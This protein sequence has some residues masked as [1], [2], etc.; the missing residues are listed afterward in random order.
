MQRFSII[1]PTLNEAENIHPLL[2][3]IEQV[4]LGQDLLPEVIFVDDG[5]YDGTC[6]NIESYRGAFPVRLI[7]RENERGL[8]GAVVAGS[9]SA[10]NDLIVVMDADLSHPPEIIPE[11][12]APL[13]ESKCD[14][15]IG[16]RY[17]KGGDTPGW[18]YYRK[19]SSQTASFPARLLSGVRDPLAGFFA[20]R[21][22]RILAV[23]NGHTGFKILLDILAD[24]ITPLV[25]RE[26]PITFHER[27]AG[28]S[29]MNVQVLCSYFSQV[30]QLSANKLPYGESS[31]FLP[32]IVL[33]GIM[34]ISLSGTLANLG[35]MH[36]NFS[37]FAGL[38]ITAHLGYFILPFLNK[39]DSYRFNWHSYL[40][41]LA[42]TLLLLFLRDGI[43]T[44]PVFQN[45]TPSVTAHFLST[46]VGLT[47]VMALSEQNIHSP[48]KNGLNWKWFGG[49]LIFYAVLIRIVFLGNIELLREEA[50]YWNYAQ[51]MAPGYLDH[52]PMV[53]LLIRWGTLMFGDNE[54]GVRFFTFLCWFITAFFTYRLTA[55]IFEKETAFRAVVLIA[56]LPIFFCTGIVS[57]PDAPVIAFWSG[58]L[59]YLYRALVQLEPRA[60]YGAGILLGLG[61]A[62]KYTIALLGPA[63][64]MF[65]LIDP[66]ARRYF[67]RPQP[68]LAALLALIIFS[69][70]IW[71]N[72]QND[73][74][75]F[76][77]Q[78]QERIQATPEFS[79]HKLL[80]SILILLTPTGFFAALAICRP[81]FFHNIIKVHTNKSAGRDYLFA[82]TMLLAPL[83]IFVL[84]SITKEI[85]LNWTGPLWLS[86]IPFIAWTMI[87]KSTK[88]SKIVARFWPKTLVTLLLGYGALLHYS[89]IGFPGIPFGNNAFLFGWDDLAQQVNEEVQEIGSKQGEKPLVA[90]M[91]KYQIASGLAFY[92]N[93]Q[94]SET[95]ESMLAN[96]TTGRQLF[97]R[98]ALMYNY[99]YPPPMANNRDILVVSHKKEWLAAIAFTDKYR[100]LGKI[101]ELTAKKKGK[102][103]G[104]YY[105][106]LLSGYNFDGFQTTLNKSDFSQDSVSGS[107]Y[108]AMKKYKEV[109]S[110]EYT[111]YR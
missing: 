74:A 76:L 110:Y 55:A 43:L 27:L 38:L 41:Y 25:V 58:A 54:L 12:V 14:V 111:R 5:S 72:F 11:L 108:L 103:A 61:L 101:Q 26:V 70:V 92:R 107:D 64:I 9:R 34:D 51:H 90:G 104:K 77:F 52:P 13:S 65:M 78:S 53:A 56:V 37:R 79:T 80:A 29:K 20:V 44:L 66:N 40:N 15:S 71:W 97:G 6:R 48:R 91:D 93:K 99:W 42:G 2:Q 57:T 46:I 96:E 7:R 4:M 21:K 49:C 67:I 19:I 89:A 109:T 35:Y 75:S 88:T 81:H 82:L 59:Y 33:L 24:G 84:V 100:K 31:L 68:Y 95:G 85:K 94:L 60:W 3:R 1:I 47:T 10:R 86:V 18:P 83:S 106:R 17:I 105:C 23:E 22:E 63:I 16:S 32:L 28:H 39:K 87:D 45:G 36:E 50:Y 62:S 8:T 69:P 98:E 30:I 73:W 102:P